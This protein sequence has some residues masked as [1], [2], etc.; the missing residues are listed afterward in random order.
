MLPF[1]SNAMPCSQFSS[2][3]FSFSSSPLGMV[4][5]CSSLPEVSNR[6]NTWS[7]GGQPS[8]AVGY[9]G[10]TRQ[11]LGD[12]PQTQTSSLSVIEKPHGTITSFHE[13]S[14]SPAWL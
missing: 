3:G 2:P 1:E 10:S 5:S 12:E 8:G 14:S 4:H 11:G 6:M 9:F 13:S 7:F